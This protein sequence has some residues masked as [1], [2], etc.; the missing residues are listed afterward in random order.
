MSL[1]ANILI[2]AFKT[3]FEGIMTAYN[4]SKSDKLAKYEMIDL[5]IQQGFPN[6][7]VQDVINQVYTAL[8]K[9]SDGFISLE[10]FNTA[11]NP[12][13]LNNLISSQM[14]TF[15]N[16][17]LTNINECL[18]FYDLNNDKRLDKM[19]IISA[20]QRIIPNLDYNSAFNCMTQLFNELDVD[21]DNYLTTADLLSKSASNFYNKIQFIAI[22][23]NT[24]PAPAANAYQTGHYLGKPD[25]V[26]DIKAR[27]DII[28]RA[29]LFLKT[30]TS[31]QPNALKVFMLPEFYFRGQRGVY[32]VE[33]ILGK[34]ANKSLKTQ[35]SEL[36]QEVAFKNWIF[37]FGTA[38]FVYLY[39]GKNYYYN[40]S[41]V[42]PGGLGIDT[43]KS[44]KV[45]IKFHR[46]FIDYIVRPPYGSIS[47]NEVDQYVSNHPRYIQLPN[48]PDTILIDD[49]GV[50]IMNG[51]T[52]GLEIC[53][54]HD[55]GFLN[56]LLP[57]PTLD[58]V[59]KVRLQLITSGGMSI[60]RNHIVR[61]I[62]NRGGLVLLCDG[63]S[64]GSQFM[65]KNPTNLNSDFIGVVPPYYNT[66]TKQFTQ[67]SFLGGNCQSI[68]KDLY[69]THKQA[70]EIFIYNSYD[71]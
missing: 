10:D 66:P 63:L 11:V 55:D 42:I 46:S 17:F 25:D 53:L 58:S 68:F 18:R 22:P 2:D 9:N 40:I 21:K 43:E 41:I 24:G 51:I 57:K 62:Q 28:R 50:F 3:N 36:V 27:V 23:L 52:I 64:A 37:V 59:D 14:I 15:K 31:I 39:Q 16:L 1:D 65:Y 12:T 34:G 54:D 48:D 7:L 29:L 67:W 13:A 61:S 60:V 69:V 33:D 20:F 30:S 45:V 4:K 56:K 32:K 38:L 35:L 19:E 44:A 47:L 49:D 71:I 26:A 6:Y 8:D 5:L 70:P